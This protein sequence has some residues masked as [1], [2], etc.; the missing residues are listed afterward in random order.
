MLE[1]IVFR[2]LDMVSIYGTYELNDRKHTEKYLKF[3]KQHTD[4]SNR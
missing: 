3:T 2:I 1:H 4:K